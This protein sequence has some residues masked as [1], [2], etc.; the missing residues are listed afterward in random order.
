MKRSILA[1][2]LMGFAGIVSAVAWTSSPAHDRGALDAFV[3]AHVEK[4]ASPPFSFLY[5]GKPSADLLGSW[6]VETATTEAADRTV[7]TVVYA[8]PSSRLRVTVVYTIYKDFPAVEWLLRFKNGGSADS[9]LIEN[10][11][12]CAARLAGYGRGPLTLY[13]AR[14][15]SGERSDFAPL[16]DA[17]SENGEVRFGPSG[18]RSSDTAALPFF[19]M[20][21]PGSGG[22]N[23]FSPSRRGRGPFA[24]PGPSLLEGERPVGRP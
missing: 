11:L 17:L 2:L 12:A 20:A 7:R 3:A 5:G 6:K 10:V 23:A 22:E 19:N 13:R 4:P 16:A 14:G 8:D 21:G 24:L 18:G 15:S 1:A 9:P